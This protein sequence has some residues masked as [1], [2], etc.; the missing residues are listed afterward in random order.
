M[1]TTD[2]FGNIIISDEDNVYV[3]KT[4]TKDLSNETKIEYILEV[5]CD[6]EKQQE[7]LFNELTEKGFI[8]RVLTL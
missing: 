1:T 8:C 5:V 6:N 3:K 4:K 2:L 7:Q